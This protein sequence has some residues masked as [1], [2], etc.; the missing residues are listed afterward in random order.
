MYA[1]SHWYLLRDIRC[2]HKKRLK[3]NDGTK[4][5]LYLITARCWRGRE[6]DE[7]IL[8]GALYIKCIDLISQ[9]IFSTSDT[10]F[11]T[12]ASGFPFSIEK[13]GWWVMWRQP[14][15]MAVPILLTFASLGANCTTWIEI[16]SSWFTWL[17]SL[18]KFLSF[19]ADQ[20]QAAHEMYP[21]VLSLFSLS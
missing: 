10:V 8:V 7:C 13:Y 12:G 15:V 20:S 5:L 4:A 9:V 3:K 17:T 21:L 14:L 1:L 2:I 16:L 11:T 18:A 19:Y 6:P